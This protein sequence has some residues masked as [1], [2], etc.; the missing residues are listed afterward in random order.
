VTLADDLDR[1]AAREPTAQYVLE[2]WAAGV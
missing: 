2:L 1:V